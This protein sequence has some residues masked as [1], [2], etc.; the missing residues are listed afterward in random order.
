MEH[1]IPEDKYQELK[2]SCGIEE[3]AM[4]LAEELTECKNC[5][6]YNCPDCLSYDNE[7][8]YHCDAEMDT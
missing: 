2:Y 3:H 8:C 7:H 6:L 4:Y 5:G 1:I